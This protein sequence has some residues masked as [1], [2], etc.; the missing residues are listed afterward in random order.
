[1]AEYD[2][3]D[4]RCSVTGGPV[5]RGTA[6]PDLAGAAL[7][8]DYCS[9]TI[10]RLDGSDGEPQVLLEAGFPI[11]SFGEGLDGEVYVLDYAAGRLLLLVNE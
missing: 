7:Y 9:G 1:V 11:S 8:A 6:I 5:Y 4:G 2:H 10:W 3:G